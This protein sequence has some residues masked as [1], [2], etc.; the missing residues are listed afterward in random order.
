VILP[1][2]AFQVTEVSVVEPWTVAENV[3]VVL[4]TTEGEAGETTTPVTVGV[5]AAAVP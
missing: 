5:E 1:F 4:T 2:A 3:M